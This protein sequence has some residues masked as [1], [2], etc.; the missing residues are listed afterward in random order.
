MMTFKREGYYQRIDTIYG[1]MIVA[2]IHPTSMPHET[3][4]HYVAHYVTLPEGP[5]DDAL[6][7]A[8]IRTAPATLVDCVLRAVRAAAKV[9]AAF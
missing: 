5:E 1:E 3:A 2:V 8:P 6:H 7:R 4:R 9:I